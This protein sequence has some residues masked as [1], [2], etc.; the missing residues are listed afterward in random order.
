M[1]IKYELQTYRLCQCFAWEEPQFI[2][3]SLSILESI[4][5]QDDPLFPYRK[6]DNFVPKAQKHQ[7]IYF[8]NRLLPCV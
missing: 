5:I 3:L 2:S 6:R 8:H 4:K 1:K 7:L